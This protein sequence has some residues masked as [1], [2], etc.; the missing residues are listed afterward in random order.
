MPG[1]RSYLTDAKAWAAREGGRR[2]AKR[3]IQAQGSPSGSQPPNHF[4][5]EKVQIYRQ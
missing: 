3:R 1:S 4:L 5:E 2:P